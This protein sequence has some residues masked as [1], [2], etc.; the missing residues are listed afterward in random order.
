MIEHMDL[1]DDRTTWT[2]LSGSDEDRFL[3]DISFGI[4]CLI[5]RSIS[6]QNILIFVD[7]P[8]GSGFV[9]AHGFPID[10]AIHPTSEFAN[11]LQSK[12]PEKLVVVVTGHG[13][14]TGIHAENNIRPYDLINTIK[15]LQS[16]NCGLL[17]LGQCFAG[18]F[19]FMDARGKG[20]KQKNKKVPDICIVGATD[21]HVSISSTIDISSVS[22]LSNFNCTKF[23]LANL[24]LFYFMFYVAFPE[25]T[26]G[27]GLVTVVDT[28]KIAGIG[29]NRQLITAKSSAFLE[30]Y[31]ILAESNINSSSNI[32]LAQQLEQKARDD[33]FS[34]SAIVL[35]SQ[36][37]WI[38]HANLA[39]QLIL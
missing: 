10:I 17:V 14:E 18:T 30:M 2:F 6:L 16:L 38:L 37:P 22:C 12:L 5:H 33:Y 27:D 34:T 21:L 7:Q 11:I 31:N 3:D 9:A 19:N 39:R 15:S 24:F 8:S 23:W 1:L 25:D 32:P 4:S 35:T 20:G 29:A 28:Y 26:D 13:T 36:N